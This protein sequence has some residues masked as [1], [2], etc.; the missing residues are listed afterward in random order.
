MD[1]LDNWNIKDVHDTFKLCIDS[2]SLRDT[3]NTENKED[4]M[5]QR[6]YMLE[7]KVS[8]FINVVD[9]YF[10]ENNNLK[11][12]TEKLFSIHQKTYAEVVTTT[13]MEGKS[14]PPKRGQ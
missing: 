14:A 12:D 3:M 10:T 4:M 9:K 5:N 6:L 13:V 2:V 7:Q 11:K 1:S 8:K